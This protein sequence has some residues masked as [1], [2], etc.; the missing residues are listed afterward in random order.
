MLND[1]T[2]L[3]NALGEMI[4]TPIFLAPTLSNC[5]GDIDHAK[6]AQGGVI[7][8]AVFGARVT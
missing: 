4:P 5:C 7:Y 8:I 6:S 2:R 1:L 3:R